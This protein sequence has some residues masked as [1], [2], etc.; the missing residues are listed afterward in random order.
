MEVATK[1]TKIFESRDAWSTHPY[2][3]TIYIK[4]SGKVFDFGQVLIADMLM[5]IVYLIERAI[6]KKKKQSLMVLDYDAYLEFAQINKI[7]FEFGVNLSN[8]ARVVKEIVETNEM[9]I[10]LK[11]TYEEIIKQIPT[12]D[13]NV[14]N[15]KICMSELFHKLEDSL[16]SG[17]ISINE[18]I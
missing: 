2:E 9:I 12:D 10:L 8:G 16:C 14:E 15:F 11:N 13:L 1:I 18:I 5:D 7:E 4:I 3:G 17:N 6:I